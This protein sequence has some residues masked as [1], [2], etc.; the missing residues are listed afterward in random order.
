MRT[1]TTAAVVVLLGA[2]GFAQRRKQQSLQWQISRFGRAN[3]WRPRA[4][5]KTFGQEKIRAAVQPQGDFSRP[6]GAVAEGAE[7]FIPANEV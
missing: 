3:T 4:R 6:V 1:V 7:G 5:A 2:T